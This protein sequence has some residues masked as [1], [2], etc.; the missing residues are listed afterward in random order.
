M[1]GAKGLPCKIVSIKS[2]L[3]VWENSIKSNSVCEGGVG[4]S[5]SASKP[6]L[7]KALATKRVR[8]WICMS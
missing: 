3:L 5:T 1:V 7:S 8:A 4:K 2:G 6:I